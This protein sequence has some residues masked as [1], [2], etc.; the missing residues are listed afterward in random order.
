MSAAL[1]LQLGL[2]FDHLDGHVDFE[3][4]F[5]ELLPP[6][7][8]SDTHGIDVVWEVQLLHPDFVDQELIGPAEWANGDWRDG[9]EQSRLS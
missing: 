1:I 2:L 6:Q 7:L 5:T 8:I 3:P 4:I 9:T